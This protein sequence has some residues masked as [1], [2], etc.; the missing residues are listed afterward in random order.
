MSQLKI[1]TPENG[2]YAGVNTPQF[3]QL[4]Y[5]IQ[6]DPLPHL[7]LFG[8]ASTGKTTAVSM[9]AKSSNKFLISVNAAGLTLEGINKAVME[10][11]SALELEHE[12]FGKYRRKPTY[13]AD[14]IHKSCLTLIDGMKVIV[15]IDEAHELPKTIQTAL[16]S[17][18]DVKIIGPAFLPSAKTSFNVTDASFVF[19]T[20][21]TSNLLYPLTTR[22]QSVI[23]DQYTKEDIKHMI[24]MKYPSITESARNILANC[25]KL[26]PRV[27]IRL[28]HQL[29]TLHNGA[30][31]TEDHASNFAKNFLNM[32][33][34]GIDSIDKR[35]L[36][37]LS[38]HKKKI[39]PSDT[40]MLHFF[41]E[42]K[43]KF[44]AKTSLST[45]DHRL[46]NKACFQ[47]ALLGQKIS[48]AEFTPKSRQDIS[49]ACRILDLRD[50]E[51]RLTF[52][53]KLSLVDKSPKGILLNERYL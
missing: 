43:A 36:L 2:F 29:V 41:T 12:K 22:L 20:T 35:I 34:N 46:Y 4:E 14:G 18:L 19:A 39:E 6:S 23:F 40:V 38:N 21:D 33:E 49:L 37:Y 44:E 53:E 42:Q 8:E 24:A 31:V 48:S 27:A 7:G 17:L 26:V 28:S 13:P 10:K 15:F 9:L 3:T 25:S 50:L 30:E 51:L 52:L 16:L 45:S 47:V 1:F 32:E 5:L 11:Y